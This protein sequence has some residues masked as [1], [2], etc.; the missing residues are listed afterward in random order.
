MKFAE[1]YKAQKDL[2]CDE[3]KGGVNFEEGSKAYWDTVKTWNALATIF[4]EKCDD[5]V[6]CIGGIDP[7]DFILVPNPNVNGNKRPPVKKK[8]S[9]K[10]VKKTA[11]KGTNKVESDEKE[12]QQ[13]NTE[14][15][16][17][18]KITVESERAPIR[19]ESR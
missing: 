15:E 14:P 13:E 18:E 8:T 11:N 12:N 16:K 3:Q 5:V 17:G 7:D 19:S 4:P 1:F 9:K 2:L 6:K 10:A